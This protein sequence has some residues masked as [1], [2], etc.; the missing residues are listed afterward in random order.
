M[1]ANGGDTEGLFHAGFMESGSPFPVGDITG[2][3]KDY[4]S[5]VQAVGCQNATDAL[6][7]LREAPHDAIKA[8]MDASN[9]LFSNSVSG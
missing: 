5:F 1:L 8:A 7:C 4:D 6:Q 3:Q 9:S 2:G